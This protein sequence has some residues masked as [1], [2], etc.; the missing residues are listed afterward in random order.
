MGNGSP[1]AIVS[2]TLSTGNWNSQYND[3][4]VTTMYVLKYE[5]SVLGLLI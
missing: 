1:F 5:K 3:S 2:F 4:A